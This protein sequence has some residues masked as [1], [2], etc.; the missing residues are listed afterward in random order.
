MTPPGTPERILF[1]GSALSAFG[2]G[3]TLPYLLI[4][5]VES[6][7][8]TLPA[9][10]VVLAIPGGV[11]LV[12]VAL[13]GPAIDRVGPLRFAATS[14]LLSVIGC[15]ALLSAGP[16][17]VWLAISGVVLLECGMSLA[18]P[19][20]QS[21][22]GLMVGAERRARFFSAQSGWS[23]A[24]FA[25]GTAASSV[26]VGLLGAGAIRMLFG[27]NLLTFFCVTAVLFLLAQ[28]HGSRSHAA[29]AVARSYLTQLKSPVRDPRFARLVALTFCVSLILMNQGEFGFPAFT[30]GTSLQPW[31][32][33]AFTAGSI[34]ATLT[35][36]CAARWLSPRLHRSLVI[37]AGLCVAISWLS[38][39]LAPYAGTGYV[40]V[41]AVLQSVGE[42]IIIAI[43]PAF[44]LA[45][46]APSMVGTYMALN[47]LA[48]QGGRMLA[49][50]VVS[51]LS[52]TGTVPIPLGIAACALLVSA[53]AARVLRSTEADLEEASR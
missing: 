29:D 48:F 39:S 21:A 3:L 17:T 22:V 11:S 42:A 13:I 27:A 47:S 23:N 10:G 6:I 45:A 8:L 16:S 25:V 26:T 2:T 7:D 51:I 1:G 31:V 37:A 30:A 15:G 18:A 35:Q 4:Y 50:L 34:A 5:L 19:A 24:L 9:A 40:F 43:L 46:A 53:L 20:L 14:S 28:S 44:V 41:F 36:V 12:G 52:A 33:A 32:G 38:L 49:P